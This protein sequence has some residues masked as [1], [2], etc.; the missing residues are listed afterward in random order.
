MRSRPSRY[1][2][3][4]NAFG[5]AF[6][7]LLHA[8]VGWAEY[9]ERPIR[10]IVP[11]GPGGATDIVA[12]S[13]AQKLTEAWG[14]P[15]VI[16]NRGGAGG[17]IGTEL[18]AKAAPD[19]Y[20]L[21]LATTSNAANVA[22]GARLPFDL[23][24]DFAPVTQLIQ[25][26]FVLTMSPKVP[27]A[28]LRELLALAKTKPGAL[29]YGT[30]GGFNELMMEQFK[31][32]ARA[33]ILRVPYKGVGPALVDLMAGRVNTMLFS[34]GVALPY[35]NDGRLRAMGVTT[36]HRVAQLPDVPPIADS[37]PG[38][39][40]AAWYGVIAPAGTPRPIVAKL[41]AELAR[42]MQSA[43]IRDSY[44]RQGFIPVGSTPQ[45]FTRAIADDIAKF[46]RIVKDAGIQP[47]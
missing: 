24:K 9:P 34:V 23:Q 29:N 21:L 28:T 7:G 37:L 4:L 20:T 8:G 6:C 18:V 32:M 16:D 12:R 38:Y 22:M 47:E 46:R 3:G 30:V 36:T 11:F 40:M 45:A 26:P 14:Q 39:D 33:D 1:R 10:F 44:G 31:S 13:V 5:W 25:A 19:G 2:L 15:V 17:T 41:S 27:A 43:E 35:L 42:V